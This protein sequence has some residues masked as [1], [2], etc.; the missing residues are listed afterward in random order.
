MNATRGTPDL[1][2]FYLLL[3]GVGSLLAHLASEFASMGAEADDVILSARHWYLGL[4]A[5][6]G[7]IVFLTRGRN[8]LRSAQN[9]R[10]LKR[11]INQ[12]L[13]ALPYGGK[14]FRFLA[15]TGGLQLAIGAMTQIGEGCP[16]CGHDVA[17]GILG[18]LATL[19]VFALITRWVGKRLPTIVGSLA[20]YASRRPAATIVS[21]FVRPDSADHTGLGV[22][23]PILFN[24]PPP[25]QFQPSY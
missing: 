10:D 16:F 8:L 7:I 25:L 5:A 22:W 14:G 9:S 13:A 12:G 2:I 19:I 4:G 1:R 20:G 15:V 11:M 21:F 3:I 24:R 17:A 18:A 6:V 23:F